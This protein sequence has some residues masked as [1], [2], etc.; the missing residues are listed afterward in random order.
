MIDTGI[1]DFSIAQKDT[2]MAFERLEDIQGK[3]GVFKRIGVRLRE[4]KT[5]N[6]AS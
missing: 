1:E 2:M 3:N 5:A 6:S 4:I